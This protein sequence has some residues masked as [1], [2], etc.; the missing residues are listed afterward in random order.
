MS[1]I[2]HII[3]GTENRKTKH[4]RR[5]VMPEKTEV[6]VLTPDEIEKASGGDMYMEWNDGFMEVWYLCP[7]CFEDKVLV[8]KFVSGGNSR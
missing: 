2:P 1:C 4:G 8:T 7:R 5:M 6:R 3:Y